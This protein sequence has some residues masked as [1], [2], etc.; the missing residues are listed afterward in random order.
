MR[1]QR[2]SLFEVPELMSNFDRVIN[3]D[4]AERLKF[5]PGLLATYPGSNFFAQVV[6]HG[7]YFADVMRYTEHVACR[8]PLRTPRSLAG[9]EA[10][11][12]IGSH[13]NEA[14]LEQPRFAQCR[15]DLAQQPIRMREL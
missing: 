10:M 3:L 1:E 4:V 12:V 6:W 11:P 13:D 9:H 14:C 15:E 7:R 2:M 5:E 8:G